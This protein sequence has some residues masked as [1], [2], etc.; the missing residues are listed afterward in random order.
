RATPTIISSIVKSNRLCYMIR[1]GRVAGVT[2]RRP[3][4]HEC[5]RRSSSPPRTG[6]SWGAGSPVAIPWKPFV[7]VTTWTVC[8][9]ARRPQPP[10]P[11]DEREQLMPMWHIYCP[12]DAYSAQEKQAFA[13]AITDLYAGFVLLP[14]FYVSV[15]FQ[16]LPADCFFIG[17]EPRSNFVRI[18]IDHI[19]A[20]TE[21]K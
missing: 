20:S 19:A 17:G 21:P 11:H 16:E 8:R 9:P 12:A 3:E 5:A 1:F 6:P 10:S 13:N 18:S 14:R 2:S 7:P 15:V 4:E